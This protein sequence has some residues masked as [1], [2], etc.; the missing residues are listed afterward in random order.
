[1]KRENSILEKLLALLCIL[2]ILAYAAITFVPHA[3]ECRNTDCALCE[4]I[5]LSDEILIGL[6]LAALFSQLLAFWRVLCAYT[7]LPS[8]REAT[9]VGRKVKLSN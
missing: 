9:P 7:Y 2:L 8:G 1:M 4:M 3:H 6:S 5:D